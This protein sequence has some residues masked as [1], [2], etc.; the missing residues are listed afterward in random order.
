MFSQ[1]KSEANHLREMRN[2]AMGFNNA[3]ITGARIKTEAQFC[4]DDIDM[5]NDNDLHGDYR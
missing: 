4:G 3:F 1:H 2:I 5:S